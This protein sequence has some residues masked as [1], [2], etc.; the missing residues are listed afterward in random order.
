LVRKLNKKTGAGARPV[1][2]Q[3]QIELNQILNNAIAAHQAGNLAAAERSYRKILKSLP[4]QPVALNLLGLI[5]M[6]QGK[7]ARAVQLLE[8]S[9]AAKPDYADAYNHLGLARRKL[10]Q[11]E[12]AL[13]SFSRAA[14][15]DPAMIEVFNNLGN[16]QKDL[17][18]FDE[19]VRSYE[20]AITLDGANFEPHYNLGN[21]LRELEQFDSAKQS[22]R[23]A[24]ALNADHVESWFN[25]AALLER[26]HEL[27][28]AAVAAKEVLIRSPALAGASLLLAK[29]L[30]RQKRFEE[31][32][33]ILNSIDTAAAKPQEAASI[34]FELGKIHDALDQPRKAFA[35][36]QQGNQLQKQNA[37]GEILRQAKHFRDGVEA[38]LADLRSGTCKWSSAGTVVDGQDPV[39]LVGFPRSGTTLLDQVLD[40]H[41]R[42]GV[43]EERPVVT[44][45]V[46]QLKSSGRILPSNFARLTGED[47]KGLRAKYF[48]QV[49]QHLGRRENMLFVDKMP[50]N[51]VH[52]P[53]LSR[54]FP[55]ARYILALR[56]PFDVVLS[57]FTQMFRL[58]G[59]MANFLELESA[60]DTYCSVM[61]LWRECQNHLPIAVHQ[62]R[63]ENLVRNL[64]DEVR[65]LLAFLGVD[66]DNA[67]LDPSGHARTRK[68]INTPSYEQ[69]AEPVH[70]KARY[71]WIQYRTELEPVLK[72]LN[73]WVEYFDYDTGSSE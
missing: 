34:Y 58:N 63:Y 57:N 69:V 41:P 62:V 56:H 39:F 8:Q 53:L 72:R 67:V 6:S 59:A 40:A 12:R 18:I 25:L 44:E 19:A 29:I 4:D 43:M 21:V 71:R 28:A 13:A 23:N 45:L 11:H 46:K 16:V 24:L 55:E 32:T 35:C 2:P 38:T 42:I 36:Y 7:N 1:S 15:L 70:E 22:Y 52:V 17:G 54:L 5:A 30:R 49:A 60:A 61:E 9:V 37:G 68:A 66:W 47:T 50:L 51:I 10:G 64:E 20:K 73:P 65:P 31:A 33:A 26:D 14:A 48:E 27:E 3:E